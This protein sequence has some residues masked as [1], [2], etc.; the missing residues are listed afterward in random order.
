MRWNDFARDDVACVVR[1]S[2]IE[3][4]VRRV[5]T[6]DDGLISTLWN[7]VVNR[8]GAELAAVQKL[9]NLLIRE[10]LVFV[11]KIHTH[12]PPEVTHLASGLTMR[13]ERERE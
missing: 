10:Q 11:N 4:L 3:V 9:D 1:P 8:I 5:V 2:D 13:R 6:T 7:L 12:P